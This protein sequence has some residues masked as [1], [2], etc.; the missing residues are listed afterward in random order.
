MRRELRLQRILDQ[1]RADL[2][3]PVG[4][5]L[6][7]PAESLHKPVAGLAQV[8]ERPPLRPVLVVALVQCPA[9]FLARRVAAVALW[10]H[11]PRWQA[12]L[13]LALAGPRLKVLLP[14]LWSRRALR[15]PR[16]PDAVRH[17]H[18]LARLK[19]LGPLEL[20][21]DPGQRRI[22]RA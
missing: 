11:R 1:Q 20:G 7:R 6:L 19:V 5:L 15:R 3:Q 4:A 2:A 17:L 18:L 21:A 12:L 16:L 8:V 13:L 9:I 22:G 10:V 14:R